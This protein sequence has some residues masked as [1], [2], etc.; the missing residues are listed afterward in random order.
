MNRNIKIKTPKE[1][2]A[3][4]LLKSNITYRLDAIKRN[5]GQI[6]KK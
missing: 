6:L 5:T 2:R 1:A 3:G 4:V